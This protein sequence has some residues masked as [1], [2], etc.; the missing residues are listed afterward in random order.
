MMACWLRGISS[1]LHMLQ[2]KKEAQQANNNGSA[3]ADLLS[4]PMPATAS[5]KAPSPE[6]IVAGLLGA[7]SMG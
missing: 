6:S 5:P 1:T 7:A 3:V 2:A 4:I